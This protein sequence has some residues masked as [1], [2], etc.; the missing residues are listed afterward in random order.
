MKPYYEDKKWL[1]KLEDIESF[2]K[3]AAYDEL[4][5]GQ[6]FYSDKGSSFAR[7]GDKF[8]LVKYEA[9]IGSAR[10]DRGDRLYWVEGITE[11]TY[12]EVNKQ[13]VI[14]NINSN[15]NSEIDGLNKQID[16]LKEKLITD[17]D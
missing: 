8:Y 3:E 1:T 2:F 9:Q 4:E 14:D 5:C 11:V 10:Q 13:T 16:K 17:L 7:I 6:G 12:E 15:I